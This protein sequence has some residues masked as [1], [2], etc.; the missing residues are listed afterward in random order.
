MS[1]HN[2]SH[3]YFQSVINTINASNVAK[4]PLT[5]KLEITILPRIKSKFLQKYL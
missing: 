5:Y 4:I 2:F 3:M 1:I